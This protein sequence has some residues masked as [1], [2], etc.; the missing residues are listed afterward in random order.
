MIGVLFAS[1][2]YGVN[3]VSVPVQLQGMKAFHFLVGRLY[4]VPLQSI[5]IVKHH[6]IHAEYNDLRLR[7][8]ESPDEEVLQQSPKEESSHI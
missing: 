2:E 8:L 3:E 7:N 1:P 6:G 5:I 4:T